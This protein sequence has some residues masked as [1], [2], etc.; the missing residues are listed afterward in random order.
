MEKMI[1]CGGSKAKH[2]GVID[3]SSLG[4]STNYIK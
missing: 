2:K 3:N 1:K 4:G